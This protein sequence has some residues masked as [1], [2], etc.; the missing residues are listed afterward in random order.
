MNLFWTISKCVANLNL[1]SYVHVNGIVRRDGHGED[2]MVKTKLN[3]GRFDGASFN[4]A[5]KL[6]GYHK[7]RRFCTILSGA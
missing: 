1:S 6:M 2:D 7:P 4:A 3:L 5:T